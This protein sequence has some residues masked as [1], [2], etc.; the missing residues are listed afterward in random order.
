M[1][2]RRQVESLAARFTFRVDAVEMV[3]RLAGILRRLDRHEGARGACL[4][5]R[6]DFSVEVRVR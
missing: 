3:L 5:R 4:Y 2:T 1:I 6:Q